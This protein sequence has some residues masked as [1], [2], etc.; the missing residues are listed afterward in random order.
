MLES[1]G[2][3]RC[4]IAGQ[5][6]AGVNGAR[7]SGG[8][9]V[10]FDIEVE[11]RSDGGLVIRPLETL[12]EYRHT[13]IDA[14][15]G[16]AVAAPAR[17]FI[18]QRAGE[19]W[20]RLSY[21]ATL[22]QVRRLAA[23]LLTRGLTAERPIL[24]LS[25]NSI[26]HQLLGLA[27]MY[28][29]VPYMPVSPAYCLV[30]GDLQRVAK[31]LDLMTPGLVAAFGADGFGAALRLAQT[32]GAQV[33]SD[34]APWL[35][36]VP[37]AALATARA[38]IGPATIAKFLLT[39][40]STGNPKAVITTQRML[41]ANQAQIRQAMPF[42]R[43]EP[44]VLVD[45]LPWNHTFGGSHNVGIV[46]ENGGTL[47]IDDGK[48]TPAGI[49]ETVRNLREL[50]PTVYFNV[51]RGF[52]MLIPHF[53]ADAPLR[54][55]FF[56]RLR[57][58]FYSG[59]AL[60]QPV[61]DALDRIA[62]AETGAPISML[63]GLGAT[64]TG[65]AVTFTT[66]QMS[67][68][69]AVGLPVAG[70]LIKLAPAGDKLEL[71]VRGP[72]VTPGYWRQPELTAK[73]FDT[74]GYYRMGDALRFIDPAA[75][76]RGLLFDGRIAEDFKLASGTWV[77]VGTLRARLLALLHPL[78]QD[79]V[80][81]GVN[82]DWLGLLLFEASPRQGDA[83]ALRRAVETRLAAFA[84]EHPQSSMAIRR[85]CLLESPPSL[86][87]GEITDK[88]SINQRSV[89]KHRAELVDRLYADDP[90]PDIICIT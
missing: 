88:G 3:R 24:I 46:L 60:S 76:E 21:V 77:S 57:T 40:G 10:K 75:P 37:D 39:S 32:R 49:A 41:C 44:P 82:R 47:Y 84:L 34:L 90:G 18:A 26:E 73:A 25:G 45:W 87:H 86:E 7:R 38:G 74:E 78:V 51:P 43:D 23:A 64:E 85:A 50:A 20:R 1:G 81:A 79:L 71:C 4:P 80:I 48:P 56:S 28:I 72:N 27:A 89:L 55:R 65:P 33:E 70:N 68:A 2:R 22:D 62:R 35:E 52:E 11:P 67:R 63:A 58:A 9:A 53:D 69:G 12:G 42:L 6:G 61:W 8:A 15:E 17:T 14:L 30:A 66:S 19:D 16:W 5:R 59:A 29:G 13:L 36:A 83:A 31:I 54:R